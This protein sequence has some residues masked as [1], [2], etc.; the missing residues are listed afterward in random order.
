MLLP[1][2]VWV[3]AL[4]RRAE[5]SGASAVVAR[6]GD[7]RAGS[8]LVKTYDT[9]TLRARVYAEAFGPDGDRLWLQPVTSEVEGEIDD[10]LARQVRYDPDIWIVEIEDRQGRHF[11][12]EKVEG[13]SPNS[14]NAA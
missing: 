11:L 4:I 10:Y 9:L 12:T 7:V 2:D 6:K 1:T 13:E 5:L 8:V 3:G 14:P